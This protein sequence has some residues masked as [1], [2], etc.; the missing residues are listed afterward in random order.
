[1]KILYKLLSSLNGREM[2]K[3][4]LSGFI[5]EAKRRTLNNPISWLDICN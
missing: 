2:L 4:N 1:M 3:G 5:M